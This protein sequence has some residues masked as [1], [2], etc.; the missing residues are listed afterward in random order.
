MA[1]IERLNHLI[2]V[3][4]GVEQSGRVLDMDSWGSATYK[5]EP[6]YVNIFGVS[7]F[8]GREKADLQKVLKATSK[9]AD[10]GF[11]ACAAGWAALDPQFQKWGMSCEI[12]SEGDLCLIFSGENNTNPHA[13]HYDNLARF[14]EISVPNS[15]FLFDPDS[16]EEELVTTAEVIS[17]IEELIERDGDLASGAVA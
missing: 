4:K 1:N 5:G 15:Y 7:S 17:R 11:A 9:I 13:I 6:E 8:G 16:Y 3:L 14:F 2:T 12:D 10:C